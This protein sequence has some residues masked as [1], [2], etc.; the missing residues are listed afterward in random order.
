M[1]PGRLLLR[2]C[3]ILL[4]LGF[5]Y[6]PARG[7]LVGFQ[8][9]SARAANVSRNDLILAMNTLRMSY[10]LPALT[11]DPIIN[12]VAQATAETMAASQMSSHIGNVSG[13]L[14]SA[15]YGGGVKV[16]AT[17][18]F[19][20]G[21]HTIDQIMVI[22]SDA[23]H[24]IPAVNPAY[25]NVGAGVAS[26]SS[27]RTYYILQAAYTA[28]KSCGEYKAPAGLPAQN[29]GAPGV[30][31]PGVPQII[32]PVKI[33]TP[34]AEGR[35]FH[36]VEAGQSFWS[37]AIAYKLT[38]ADLETW[39]NLSKDAGLKIGQKLFIPSSNTAGYATPTPVGMVMISEPGSDG[40]IIHEVQ[41]YQTLITIGQAYKVSVDRII[42]LNGILKD[43]PLQIG[44]KLV[45]STGGDSGDASDQSLSPIER[46]TPAADGRY[47]HTV[48]SGETLSFIAG[49]Y[50]IGLAELMAWNGLNDGST[51]F[52]DQKLVLMVT[53][54][55]TL[56]PTPLPTKEINFIETP[57]SSVSDSLTPAFPPTPITD[58]DP[59]SESTGGKNG[60]IL[61]FAIGL[62]LG[63]LALIVNSTLRRR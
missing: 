48:K 54:P 40:K 24:M 29:G 14:A 7:L 22:W 51:I 63:G 4:I 30:V 9:E 32:V 43:T 61:V 31:N 55:A 3:L 10:G 27:G 15:G 58:Q 21:D 8:P 26:S 33:A 37:I 16:W 38:I 56:T 46:L 20:V 5:L 57:Q 52:P 53:P 17:E 13:R 39:N 41:P 28:T 12:A 2:V 47:Y 23:A 49:V 45:I 50:K 1:S 18:N 34:N 6:H 42:N 11:E 35:I 25:C 60:L 36:I 44:Q 19:A 62:G 59:A